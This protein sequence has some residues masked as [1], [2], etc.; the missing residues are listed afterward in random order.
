MNDSPCCRMNLRW[1]AIAYLI[2]FTSSRFSLAQEGAVPERGVAAQPPG[3]SDKEKFGVAPEDNSREFLRQESVLLKPCEWQFDVGLNY[4]IFDHRFTDIALPNNIP[5]PVDSLVRRRLLV[6]PLQIRYGLT[7]RIQLFGSLPVGWTNTEVSALNFDSFTNAGGIGDASAGCSCLVHKS[8]GSSCDPDVIATFGFAA[9]TS[10]SDLFAAILGTPQTVLGQGVWAGFWNVLFVH[11]YDPVVVFYG[12][13][14]W[15]GFT[16]EFEGVPVQPGDQYTYRGGVGFAVNER[17]T[18]STM[19]YGYYITEARVENQRV[20]GT[21][22]EPVYL[23]FAVTM[24]Q[25]SHRIC[26]P[27]AEIGMTTDAANA[28]FGVTWTF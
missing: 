1:L 16:R 8:C 17:I 15:H 22:Q 4:T 27:F 10:N 11:T 21:T 13:G 25:Q 20:L 14:S 12:F 18:L 6:M 23:R 24:L 19:L 7:D 5:V 28:R 9:P 2:V 26:E 3:V